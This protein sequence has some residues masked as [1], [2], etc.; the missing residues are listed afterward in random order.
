MKLPDPKDVPQT[1]QIIPG[2]EMGLVT[3]DFLEEVAKIAREH[4]IPLI[5]ITS[6]QRLGFVGLNPEDEESLR[7]KLDL[8]E[9]RG[10]K[11]KI[12]PTYIQACPGKGYCK[13][14]RHNS[15][16]LGKRL[17][18]ELADIELPAKV[19]IGVSGCAMNCCES[20][21]RDLGIFGKKKGWTL[22]FGGNG[23]G[24]PRIADVIASGLSDDQV[25]ALARAIL[26]Y[27]GSQARRLERTARFMERSRLSE[28]KEKL[29]L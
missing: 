2:P 21:I 27:Y 9:P 23:G 5:K 8:P 14:G 6:A 11:K 29:G 17:E 25:V 26:E 3:P 15:L 10:D 24:N 1:F 12:G 22:V 28:I 20:Y 4:D 16:S 7:A 18:S 19:K 13:Y